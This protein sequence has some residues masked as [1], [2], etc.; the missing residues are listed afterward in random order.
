[1]LIDFQRGVLE[2]EK[3]KRGTRGGEERGEG[4]KKERE[5]EIREKHQSVASHML[6]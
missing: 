3:G 2:E 1:M 6:P 5:R 4:R